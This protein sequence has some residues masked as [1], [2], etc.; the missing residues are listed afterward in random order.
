MPEI[1]LG[2]LRREI[3]RLTQLPVV[4]LNNAGGAMP[5]PEAILEVI[6]S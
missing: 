1:N 6:R 2:Q 5:G 4:G 3:E